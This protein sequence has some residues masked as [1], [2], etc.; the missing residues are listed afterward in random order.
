M[1]TLMCLVLT[2]VVT[3]SMSGWAS[4][5][6]PRGPR[7]GPGG[8]GGPGPLRP[9]VL[10]RIVDDLQLSP[11]EKEKVDAIVAAHE[12]K[13]RQARDEA[14]KALLEQMKGVLNDKQYAQFKQ[15]VERRPPPP[16]AGTRG[17]NIDLLVDHVMNFDKNKDGKVTKEELP[18]R[19]HYLFEIGDANKDGVL[20]RE[21]IKAVATRINLPGGSAD[22]AAKRADA[23][24]RR[25]GPTPERRNPDRSDR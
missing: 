17:V 6:P 25:L 22:E 5:Q 2:V 23:P 9:E 15:E 19:L 12:A 14:R 10:E 1:Q 24:P 4:A 3:A 18:D 8:P 11:G 16:T 20:T 13:M 21:E 7:G